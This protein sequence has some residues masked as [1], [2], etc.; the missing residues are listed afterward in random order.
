MGI[1]E[2]K[3]QIREIRDNGGETYD[4]YTI[5]LTTR[6]CDWRDSFECI[7]QSEGADGFD[8]MSEAVPGRH[9]GK[10]IF[11][12]DLPQGNRDAIVARFTIDGSMV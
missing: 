10:L 12:D 5:V 1:N 6:F 2:I 11:W 8:E 7:G 9:L 4:R 3:K